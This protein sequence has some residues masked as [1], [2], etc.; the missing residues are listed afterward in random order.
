MHVDISSNPFANIKIISNKRL[1][2]KMILHNFCA[3]DV[4]SN[5]LSFVKNNVFLLT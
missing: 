5:I 3:N 1:I 4:L 2:S